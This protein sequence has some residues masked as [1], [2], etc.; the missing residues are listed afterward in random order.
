MQVDMFGSETA[1]I[2]R[3]PINIKRYD[4]EQKL[5]DIKFKRE[6]SDFVTDF[7]PA[8][9][10]TTYRSGASS[11]ADVQGYINAGSPIGICVMDASRPVRTL[12]AQYVS[13]GG[14]VFIDSGAFRVFMKGLRSPD[15]AP[16]DFNEVFSRY[17][18]VINQCSNTSSLIVVAPDAVGD[19]SFSYQLLCEYIDDITAMH[20]TGVSIMVPMQKGDLS[21]AEHYHRCR[22][23][24][25]FDFVV[26]LPSNAE[27]LSK[28]EVFTFLNAVHPQRVH[29]LG[30]AE[31]ALVHEAKYRSPS[32]DF[33]CDA[34]TL[35]KHIGKDRLL[36]EMQN[37][38]LDEISIFAM[39]GSR[40][41][42]ISDL[43][44]WDE[45]EVIGDLLG[46]YHS[47]PAN[48]QKRF[49]NE[50]DTSIKD[51][52]SFDDNDDLWQ[53]LGDCTYD[54]VNSTCMFFHQLCRKSLGPRIRTLT[55]STLA[56][57]EII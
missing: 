24:L 30:C 6:Q 37:Q 41:H 11:R 46:F 32:T 28:Q 21:I 12:V 53:H 1:P 38:L 48:T 29:F 36:S 18:D 45:T 56:D 19:Q 47:L 2:K 49:A 9:N 52:E 20:E 43:R 54:P 44:Q 7:N 39:H 26:G 27:A 14:H 17:Y 50:L 31:S 51:I 42:R 3:T 15:T 25:G 23:L 55:V 4:W 33:S 10:V 16:I 34:T 5:E 35:R 13:G 40:N 57:L 8:S 22:S